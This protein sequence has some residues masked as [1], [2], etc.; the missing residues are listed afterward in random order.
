MRNFVICGTVGG[1]N[2]WIPLM[3]QEKM[4]REVVVAETGEPNE[5]DDGDG[6]GEA[7]GDS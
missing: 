6:G 3:F 2:G 5:G 1:R 4:R 7:T